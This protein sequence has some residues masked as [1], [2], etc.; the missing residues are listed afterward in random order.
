M[1][2]SGLTGQAEPAGPRATVVVAMPPGAP[3]PNPERTQTDE[4]LRAERER[5]DDALAEEMAAIDRTADEVVEK[6]RARADA[7]LAAARAK[8]DRRLSSTVMSSASAIVKE[9][10]REDQALQTER[11][12]ADEAL[13]IER[14]NHVALLS[15]GRADTD[16]DLSSERTRSDEAV[17]TREAFMGMVSHDL[18]NMLNV[19]NGSALLIAERATRPNHTD[20][21]LLHAGRIQRA[22]ARMTRLVGDL[23]DVASIEAGA[24]GVTRELADPI[25]VVTEAIESF[26]AIM[27]ATEISLTADMQPGALLAAFDSARILQVLVNL[28]GNAV[29][30][31][32]AKGRIAVSVEATADE[33]RFAVR[34]SGPGIP[35]DQL[36]AVFERFLQV[37]S[38][39]RGIG[40][41]LYI[42]KC[43]V[44]GHGGRIW[45][46]SVL[47]H[48]SSFCFTLPIQAA[49]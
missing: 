32:P 48:G 22:H 3:D 19:M 46:E 38:D 9:R 10:D 8:T 20:E 16:R 34:D 25:P 4:S 27:P 21:V 40:L 47:G 30:F 39:R 36:E 26:R 18:R 1:R 45:A 35:S 2:T 5:T 24:L 28:I 23:V 12:I 37:K 49:A 7:V 44:Q 14:A 17:A 31:T 29:K 42:S 15:T 41:G 43:I 6:A 11:A 33:I 13:R